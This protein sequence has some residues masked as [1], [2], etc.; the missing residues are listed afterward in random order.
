MEGNEMFRVVN[1]GTCQH[2]E[3]MWRWIKACFVCKEDR[4]VSRSCLGRCDSGHVIKA[5]Q[6][7][8]GVYVLIRTW[9]LL[10]SGS[11]SDGFF[12][13]ERIVSFTQ[14]PALC[15]RSWSTDTDH[16]TRVWWMFLQIWDFHIWVKDDVYRGR[17]KSYKRIKKKK[18]IYIYIYIYIQTHRH[19]PTHRHMRTHTHTHRHTPTHRHMRTHTHTHTHTHSHTV[20]HTQT[21]TLSLSHTHTHTNTHSYTLSLSLTHTHTH[22]LSLSHTQTHT[23]SLSLSLSLS[24]THTHTF[25]LTHTLLFINKIYIINKR[26]SFELFIN[27]R[28]THLKITNRKTAYKRQIVYT[29]IIKLL[30]PNIILSN[31][32]L[33]SLSKPDLEPLSQRPRTVLLRRPMMHLAERVRLFLWCF[34]SVRT[35]FRRDPVLSVADGTPADLR[36]ASAARDALQT[37]G[38]GVAGIC[39]C[40]GLLSVERFVVF[41]RSTT[42]RLLFLGVF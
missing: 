9:L 3:V 7:V 12:Q 21:H 28:K 30:I 14:P 2:F 35:G 24:L 17:T 36:R 15:L 41:F 18:H 33:R 40:F 38:W 32:P 11:Y 4:S 5:W 23:F 1:D 10:W 29:F 27:H 25:S 13:R 8:T 19:T 31:E 26:C 42:P 6:E 16:L 20:S 39:S 37:P 22:F 34:S